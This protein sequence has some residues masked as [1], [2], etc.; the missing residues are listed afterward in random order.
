MRQKIYTLFIMS[1]MT[2]CA[3]AETMQVKSPDGRLTVDFTLTD[4]RL[5]YAVSY[6]NN[7][8]IQSSALGVNTEMGDFTQGLTL[9]NVRHSAIDE[10]YT[11]RTAKCGGNHYVANKIESEREKAVAYHDTVAPKMEEIRYQIDKLEL[12]VADELWTLPKYRELLFI[13]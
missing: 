8:M 13:R 1:V 7:E 10:A 3:M 5:T 2:V 12:L 6:D 9:K 11:L 4:G